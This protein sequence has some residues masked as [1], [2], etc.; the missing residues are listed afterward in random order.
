VFPALISGRCPRLHTRQQIQISLAS[1]GGQG[2]K[3]VSP[4][5][6]LSRSGGR[7]GYGNRRWVASRL[8]TARLPVRGSQLQHRTEGRRG[9]R[10]RRFSPG[11][12][13]PLSAFSAE[14]RPLPDGSTPAVPPAGCGGD[15]VSIIPEH[16]FRAGLGSLITGGSLILESQLQRHTPA[17]PAAAQ[18]RQQLLQQRLR[19]SVRARDW[20]WGGGAP[21]RRPWKIRARKRARGGGFPPGNPPPFLG[22]FSLQFASICS[23]PVA[24]SHGRQVGWRAARERIRVAES[25]PTGVRTSWR[26]CSRP[27]R[28]FGLECGVLLVPGGRPGPRVGRV[29]ARAP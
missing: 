23:Q 21:V 8:K 22:F 25:W 4:A 16:W 24:L 15:S 17:A 27:A 20:A 19:R 18:Q 9:G 1:A 29:D 28:P 26:A 12:L 14:S 2:K 13:R 11:V 6:L 10:S 3:T 5:C 7:R